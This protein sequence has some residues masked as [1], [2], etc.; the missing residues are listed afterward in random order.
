MLNICTL[1]RNSENYID[2]FFKQ[3]AFLY[4]EEHR[5]YVGTGDNT[6]ETLKWLKIYEHSKPLT[7]IDVSHGGP[8]IGSVISQQR[9]LQLAYAGNLVLMEASKKHSDVTIWLDADI[10]FE[11]D[12]LIKLVN[13]LS[14]I[15]AVHVVAPKILLHRKGFPSN[16]F[17]DTF[18]FRTMGKRFKPDYPY[19]PHYNEGILMPMDSVGGFVVMLTDV[20]TDVYFPAKDVFIGLCA[21]A[22][23]K[24]HN[25][26]M[27][28]ELEVY[29]E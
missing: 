24:G 18:C 21:Q 9:F 27:N 16:T 25:I 17:Y 28:T 11:E 26:Y 7:V 5:I 29:H 6:D 4:H 1:M 22:T 2:R 14:Y 19:S 8:E 15:D 13:N 12:T 10:V 3:I 20:A 23:S